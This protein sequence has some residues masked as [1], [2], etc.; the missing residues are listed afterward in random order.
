MANTWTSGGQFIGY[1]N[2]TQMN[3]TPASSHN[4][5]YYAGPLNIGAPAW[6]TV[7]SFL[8]NGKIDEVR[9]SNIARSGDWIKTEY[10]N[11]YTPWNFYYVG[12]EQSCPCS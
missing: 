4:I 11:M 2:G 8:F 12:S 3:T 6:V 7:T 5:G 1:I 9:I 10:T